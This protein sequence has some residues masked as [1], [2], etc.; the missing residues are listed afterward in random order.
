VDT[1]VDREASEGEEEEEKE[2]EEVGAEVAVAALKLELR[3]A[4]ALFVQ[5]SVPL[6]VLLAQPDAVTAE[7][8]EALSELVVVELRVSVTVDE[9]DA[10]LL[11][12]TV[13]IGVK[14]PVA[15]PVPEA[16]ADTRDK[17]AVADDEDDTEAM[18]AVEDTVD[19]VVGDDQEPVALV[20]ALPESVTETELETVREN[21]DAV[22]ET[23]P[24]LES[25]K[26]EAVD[27]VVGLTEAVGDLEGGSKERTE[28]GE[29]EG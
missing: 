24:E 28:D 26:M 18:E 2:E 8:D 16:E 1:E 19:E 9:R 13:S 12:E 7:D 11:P 22:A 3:L 6:A 5:V 17:V 15:G 25:V 20:D 27:S 10:K 23:V 29:G 4:L 21:M 14:V